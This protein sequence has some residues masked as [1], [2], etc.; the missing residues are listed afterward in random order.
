[1]IKTRKITF[2]KFV[3]LVLILISIFSVFYIY[4]NIETKKPISNQ[5]N[6]TNNK[7][8]SYKEIVPGNT[9]NENEINE[10]LGVPISTINIEDIKVSD[11]KSTN[12]YRN[13]Q[14]EIE[15]GSIKFIREVVNLVDNKTADDIRKI[16]GIAPY[17]L[18][19]KSPSSFFDL[20][21]YPN[22]GIAYIG[23]S[24]GTILEIWYYKPTDIET[25]ISNFASNYQKDIYIEQPQY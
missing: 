18:Y 24:D 14:I 23:H 11:Y 5:N 3:I 17:I 6:T 12:E 15:N 20:Y 16:Y 7:I 25:F 13:H 1:M 22:N 4:S 21:V 8:S 10:K 2:K 19:E 9:F